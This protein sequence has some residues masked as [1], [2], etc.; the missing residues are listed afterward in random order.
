MGVSFTKIPN[1]FIDEYLETYESSVVLIFF[2]IMRQTIGWQKES[3]II[4]YSIFRKATGLGSNTP[5]KKALDVLKKDNWIS[6]EKTHG[7]NKI[8]LNGFSEIM[9]ANKDEK[10]TPITLGVK[11]DITLSVSKDYT[12]CT[13]PPTLS[14]DINRKEEKKK[15]KDIYSAVFETFWEKYPRSINKKG[16]FRCWKARLKEGITAQQLIEARDVYIKKVKGKEGEYVLHGS[17]FLGPN[18][19]WKD[20][21]PKKPIIYEFDGMSQREVDIILKERASER[22]EEKGITEGSKHKGSTVR[23]SQE[24]ALGKNGS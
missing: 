2:T 10:V 12:E 17:T 20:F 3:A 11:D 6:I 16:S 1:V 14:V 22:E 5:I 9:K 19:R 21:Q 8:I 13:A 4:P 7:G 15:K 23:G 24:R 18:E